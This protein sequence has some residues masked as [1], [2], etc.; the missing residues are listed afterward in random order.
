M[1]RKALFRLFS[2][3]ALVVFIGNLIPLQPGLASFGSSQPS[4]VSALVPLVVPASRYDVSPDLRSVSP[5]QP[6]GSSVALFP[7]EIP[8]PVLPKALRGRS[9]KELGLLAPGGPALQSEMP[10]PVFN[11]DGIS[12]MFGGWP[13]DTQGDIGP[14][15]YIQW[16]NLHFA[17][18]E[19][20]RS[21][22]TA[23]I[24]YGPAPGN[25]LFQGFGGP[26][27]NT[28]HGD[29]ITLY[30]PFADRWLM[31]QFAL[32]NYPNGPFYQCVAVS[33]SSDPLGG[34]Y[35]YEYPMPTNKMNDY[36]KFG[37]WPDAYFMTVNQYNSGTL[38]WG[39]AAAA[40]FDRAAML[41]GNPAVMV[42]FD[43]F[44]VNPD[45]GGLLPADFDGLNSPPDGAPGYFASWDDGSWIGPQDAVRIWEFNVD[46]TDPGAASF[47]LDGDP[48][49][50]L[51][52]ANVD[53]SM[54]F[55]M[56]NCIPQPNTTNKLD[57][58]SDRLMYRLQYRNF[59]GYAA[60]GLQPH[61]G[62]GWARPRRDPLVRAAPTCAGRRLEPLPGRSLLPRMRT[63]AG[64]AAP[65][66]IISVTWRLAT[67]SPA[68]RSTLPSVSPVG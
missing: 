18:W 38:G 8:N 26:C 60:V 7:P 62:F 27:Q 10:S 64:W 57:A 36:P 47:G 63:T 51:P 11:F 20:D 16:I 45:Y 65:R 39:G 54:C 61:R 52:T 66:W 35:R 48:N 41:S 1:K 43:L 55:M 17:I 15:H 6:A 56:R 33:T 9:D 58:I 31:S 13:P 59:G 22:L 4:Q 37:V 2:L 30:D 46:W 49:W 29:P 32:P 14:N 53:P 5:A 12:N 68:L 40:A 28:N 34:W 3:L 19:I 21:S 50:V 67:A 25:T 23:Q 24:V 42:F 44:G